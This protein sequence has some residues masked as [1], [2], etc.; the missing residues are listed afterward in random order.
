MFKKQRV[1]WSNGMFLAPQHFQLQDEYFEDTLQF[2]LRTSNFANWGL[3]R[4]AIDEAALANGFFRIR[5][6]QGVLP[7]GLTFN[8]PE[9]DEIPAGRTV[10]DLF[11]PTEQTLDVLLAIPEVKPFGQNFSLANG[12]NGEASV[13]GLSTR[14]AAEVAVIPDATEASEQRPVQLARKTY[15]L[16]LEGERLDGFTAM[17]IAQI[18]RNSK[19]EYILS[20]KFIPPL[21]D[22]AASDY[23][24]MLARRQIEVLTA[25]SSSLAV[26]RRAKGRDLAD[27]TTSEVANFWLLHTVN[28]YLPDL[29]H[30]W[31]IRRGHPDVLFRAML[32]LAGALSTFALEGHAVDLPDYDHDDLGPSFTDLDLRIRD[33]LETVLPSKCLAIP[34]T[35]TDKLV[36][37]CTIPDDRYLTDS[38]AFLSV[39]A[40]M[41]V[42][43]VISKFPRLAKVSSPGEIERLVRKSLPGVAL[44]HTPAPPPAIPLKLDNQY[45]S[46]GQNGSLWDAVAQSRTLSVFA[47]GEIVNPKMEL[48]L[49][50]Q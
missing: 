6:C 23:L 46:L 39:S 48:L 44:R 12:E 45:F 43:E 33:L 24:M 35:L 40:H 3:S 32:R 42:D 13:R 27:F 22:I 38:Q 41:A 36:W 49:V 5:Y 25:K 28:T 21:L 4:I 26:P 16:L 34:L 11:P 20:P 19:G 2:R 14:F 37:S 31:K 17:R 50:L 8:M 30:I 29:K 18:A 1:V 10:E 15:R 47:P 7:D 9:A